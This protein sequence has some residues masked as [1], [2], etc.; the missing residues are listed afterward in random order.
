M[1][2]GP[3]IVWA[4][5]ILKLLLTQSSEL[6]KFPILFS[7]PHFDKIVHAILF[8]VWMATI[9]WASV[10]QFQSKEGW[11]VALPLVL[12]L[13]VSTELIQ[14]FAVATR[15]G[16]FLDLAADI[17]GAVVVLALLNRR[18]KAMIME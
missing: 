17:A 3:S 10:K 13:G 11:K 6:P 16:S 12:V 14:E 2:L 5:L 18:M 15:Q 4:L 7:I 1:N 9:L 8:G